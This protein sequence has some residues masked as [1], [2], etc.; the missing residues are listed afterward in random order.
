MPV[1]PLV[2]STSVVRPGSMRPSRSAAAS[3]ETP[4]RSLTLPARVEGLELGVDL[5]AAVVAEDAV[6]P[7]HRRASDE[8]RDVDRDWGHSP[9]AG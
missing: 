6:E 3:I 1:L 8:F 5:G 4:M 9:F 2:A 7:H